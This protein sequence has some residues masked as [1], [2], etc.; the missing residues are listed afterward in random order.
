MPSVNGADY[1]PSDPSSHRSANSMGT[2]HYVSS[3]V[4][5]AP[6]DDRHM[7]SSAN[8]LANHGQFCSG[9]N[10]AVLRLNVPHSYRCC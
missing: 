4:S 6:S 7:L 2:G 1:F 3:S 10:G 9:P 8:A 5:V